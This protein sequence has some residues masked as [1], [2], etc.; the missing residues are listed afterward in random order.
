MAQSDYPTARPYLPD[1]RSLDSLAEAAEGCRGCPLYRNSRQVVFGAGP[2]DA[3]IMLIGEQPGVEEDKVGQPFLGPAG[4]LLDDALRQAGL[5]RG[6]VYMTNAVKHFKSQSN[7]GRQKSITPTVAE[8]KA[9]HPWLETE[10]ETVQPE[11]LVA[12]GSVAARSILGRSVA[13]Q[14]SLD[15]WFQAEGGRSLIVTY[16]PAA[17][18][19]APQRDDQERLFNIIARDLSRAREAITGGLRPGV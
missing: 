8:I 11:V 17:A 1:D 18:L 19:R 15:T 6:Q 7:N 14:E 12:L 4:S 13:I 3:Q 16:H 10:I 9:C 2:P 5:D